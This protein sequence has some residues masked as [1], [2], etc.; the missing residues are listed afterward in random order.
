MKS[1][2]ATYGMIL[3]SLVNLTVVT[4]V[5]SWRPLRLLRPSATVGW[6]N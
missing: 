2:I 5:H 4:L 6:N 1:L 3:L